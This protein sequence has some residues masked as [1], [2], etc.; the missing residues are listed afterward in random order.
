M[1]GVG[2]I[3]VLANAFGSHFKMAIDESKMGNYQKASTIIFNLLAINPLMYEESNPVG[4]KEV[5][6]QLVICENY[7]RMPLEAASGALSSKISLAL[8]EV[9]NKF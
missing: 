4:I 2:V 5:L 6:K 7:V 3:S 8:K 9:K 1:G